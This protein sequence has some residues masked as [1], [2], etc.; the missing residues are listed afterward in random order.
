MKNIL[1][2]LL[3][4]IILFA[5]CNDSQK[6]KELELKEKELAIKEKELTLKESESY[7]E[8]SEQIEEVNDQKVEKVNDEA[9]KAADI[10]FGKEISQI[11]KEL[12]VSL[13]LK[14]FHTGDFT[15]DNVADIAVYYSLTPAGG[16]NILAGQGMI[17]YENY[18]NDINRIAKYESD[19]LFSFREI[20][21]GEVYVTK[22][23]FEEGDPRCCPSIQTKYKLTIS[24]NRVY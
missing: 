13:D 15:G 21:N 22:L 9:I 1:P 7:S 18:G 5:S 23:E 24:G 14:E 11:E 3:V 16:G 17:L 20:K 8:T 19:Y 2:G 12:E 4:I 6:K 10:S